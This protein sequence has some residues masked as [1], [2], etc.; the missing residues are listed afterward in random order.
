MTRTRKKPAQAEVA[1]RTEETRHDVTDSETVP[2]DPAAAD[3][4]LT[5]TATAEDLSAFAE[6]RH[7][8]AADRHE[9]AEQL[10]E[11][12]RADHDETRR[13]IDHLQAAVRDRSTARGADIA[14]AEREAGAAEETAGYAAEAARRKHLAR[15]DRQL[16][17][18]RSAERERLADELAGIESR[19]AG[20]EEKRGH[21]AGQ[22]DAAEQVADDDAMAGIQ[23]RLDAAD[24][25]LAVLRG[26]RERRAA[27]I[28]AIGDGEGSGELYD[29]L[30]S[31]AQH[32]AAAAEL[33]HRACP[34]TPEARDA[35]AIADALAT[36]E[37]HMQPGGLLG[38]PLQPQRPTV[39]H[40]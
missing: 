11:E 35:A 2:G 33:I 19:L 4:P 7:A 36:I 15:E 37:V 30:S 28:E 34:D 26:Q 12:D 1:A 18:G 38:P 22:Y 16:A 9:Y 40:L 10:R 27:R 25:A 29:A 21:L 20:L 3:S 31:A 39:V 13:K 32:E 8:R 14:A 17:D 5:S 24:K 6:A 23:P